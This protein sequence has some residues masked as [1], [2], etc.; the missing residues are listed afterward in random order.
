MRIARTPALSSENGWNLLQEG[1]LSSFKLQAQAQLTR[2]M[3]E[4]AR[5]ACD[6]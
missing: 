3:P 4:D 6:F 2:F 5:H 1:S